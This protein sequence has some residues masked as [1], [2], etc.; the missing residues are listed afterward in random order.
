LD[1]RLCDIFRP[2]ETF[3]EDRPSRQVEYD[4]VAHRLKNL[5]MK[6]DAS[7]LSSMVN[8]STTG[9]QRILLRKLIE[10]N[11][12]KNSLSNIVSGNILASN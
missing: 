3:E 8:D 6:K 2:S 4:Q 12:L 5:L 10:E 11:R 9:M 1:L 7:W